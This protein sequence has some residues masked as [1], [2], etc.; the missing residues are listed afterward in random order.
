M[1]RGAWWA[2]VHAC[3]DTH[4]TVSGVE[5]DSICRCCEMITT[6]SLVNIYL[7]SYTVLFLVMR[8]FNIYYLSNFQMCNTVLI[9]IVASAVHYTPITYFITRN[10]YLLIPFIQF[11]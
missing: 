9:T 6:V 4:Y 5:H 10:L 7:H 11:T 8:T 1:D 2:T 3:T